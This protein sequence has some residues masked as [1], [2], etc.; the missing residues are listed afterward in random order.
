MSGDS[1]NDRFALII[2]AMLIVFGGVMSLLAMCG[3]GK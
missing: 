1:S 3:V 2:V